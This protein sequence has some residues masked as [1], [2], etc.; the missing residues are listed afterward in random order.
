MGK[1]RLNEAYGKLPLSFEADDGQAIRWQSGGVSFLAKLGADARNT[2]IA[3]RSAASFDVTAASESIVASFG[4]GLATTSLAAPTVPLPT[5]LDGTSVKVR[6]S[7]GMERLA[8][9]LFVS[10]NQINFQIPAGT[11]VGTATVIVNNNGAVTNLGPV[12]IAGVAPGIFTANSSGRGVPVALALRVQPGA[13]QSYEP[14]AVFDAAQNSFVARPLDL[15]PE[16]DQVFLVLF[17]TGA[18]FRSTLSAVTVNI[19]GVNAQV[20]YAGIQPDLVGLDQVNVRLPRS[21]IGRGDVDLTL[22]VD[23]QTANAVRV[24]FK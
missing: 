6:D 10:P 23:G 8:P 12:S 14:V 22:I 1:A 15:G 7:S 5:S 16:T 11:S 21:L 13:V 19:G 9:L 4:A 20:V 3:T 17:C 24:N 2:T 18:R